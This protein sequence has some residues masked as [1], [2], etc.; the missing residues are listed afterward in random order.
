[1]KSMMP[2][3]PPMQANVF[4]QVCSIFTSTLGAGV[5]LFCWQSRSRFAGAKVGFKQINSSLLP[6]MRIIY[7]HY[8]K[9][10]R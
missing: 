6:G 1:V 4:L 7:K 9:T 2:P 10:L 8:S 5:D 3:L